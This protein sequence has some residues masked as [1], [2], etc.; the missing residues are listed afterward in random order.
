M[1]AV[2]RIKCH[3]VR[4]QTGTSDARTSVGTASAIGRLAFVGVLTNKKP[5]VV[6]RHHLN[7]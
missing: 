6:M 4:L 1:R 3:K 5:S 2:A 7:S